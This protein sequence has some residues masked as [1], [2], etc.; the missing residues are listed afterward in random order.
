MK[1]NLLLK[2]NGFSSQNF[3]VK[4]NVITENRN[5]NANTILKTSSGFGG[6]NASAILQK[7]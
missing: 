6:F 5:L 7:I 2:C 3:D 4:L 1:N